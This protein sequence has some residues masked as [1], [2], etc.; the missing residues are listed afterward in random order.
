MK[1]KKK[2][3]RVGNH[4]YGAI[5]GKVVFLWCPTFRRF[6]LTFKMNKNGKYLQILNNF[7]LSEYE[8]G[9]NNFKMTNTEIEF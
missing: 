5:K 9:K 6:W 7:K 2:L 8:V 3:N 1:I 4:L